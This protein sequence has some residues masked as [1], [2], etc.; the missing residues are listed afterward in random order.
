MEIKLRN[1][2]ILVNLSI[3]I[4]LGLEAARGAPKVALLISGVFL[5][6]LVNVIFWARVKKSRA[7]EERHKS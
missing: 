2:G 3:A 5:Y 6:A 4:G 1:Q 7:V